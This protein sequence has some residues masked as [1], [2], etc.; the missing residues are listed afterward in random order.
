MSTPA[1]PN[2]RAE[3]FLSVAE[4]AVILKVSEVTLYRGISAGEFPAIKIRGR[5]VIPCK[6]LDELEEAALRALADVDDRGLQV[7]GLR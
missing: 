7:G 2:P 6:A 4:A 3:R 5:Y 1:G